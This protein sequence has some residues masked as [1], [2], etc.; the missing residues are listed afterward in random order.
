MTRADA[1]DQAEERLHGGALADHSKAAG[2]LGS[3]WSCG[4]VRAAVRASCGL[5]QELGELG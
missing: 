3:S 2:Q 1:L 4:G 5:V